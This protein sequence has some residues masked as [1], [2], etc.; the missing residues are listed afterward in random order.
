MSIPVY[1]RT[2]I[3]LASRY[4]TIFPIIAIC[5]PRQ[6][7][8]T[9]LARQAF[10]KHPYFS[11]EDIDIKM[12]FESDPRQF[13]ASLENGAIFDEVQHVP[14]LFSYLQG[15]VDASDSNGRFILTSSQN[16]LLNERIT[17]SLAGRVGFITL[18]PLSI[19]ELDKKYSSVQHMLLGGYPRLHKFE[20]KPHEFY[21]SYISSYLERDVRQLRNVENLSL[22]QTFTKMCAARIGQL[23]NLSS[24][25][26][27]CGISQTTARDWLTLLEA[28]YLV[29][30]LRPYHNNFNKR[31]TKMPKLYFYDTGL[32]ASL[33]N[34]AT[35]EQLSVHYLKGSLFENLGICQVIKARLN[36]GQQPAVFFWRDSVGR[37][38]DLLDEWA[39]EI[40]LFE[41]KAGFTANTSDNKQLLFMKSL[42]PSARSY[43]VYGSTQPIPIFGETRTISVEEIEE[44]V[45]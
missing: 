21:P 28:S 3:D 13:L 41:F 23:L 43:L 8:K 32:A 22:F 36:N 24:L 19:S 7:G 38:V 10:A 45:S 18:L 4:A 33:L 29:F 25:A 2:A 11:F 5:G 30:L 1:H 27:D 6:S 42:I 14:A 44:N 34:I 9:T 39:G 40:R 16:F 15:V 26:Q 37:E 20:M 12:R 31:L 17:Q 35:E